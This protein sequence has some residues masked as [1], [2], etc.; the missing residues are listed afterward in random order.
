MSNKPADAKREVAASA[1]GAIE[2]RLVRALDTPHLAD[3]VP[4]LP[5][6]TLYQVVRLRGVEHCGD[7]LAAA[8]PAQLGSLLDLDLWRSAAAGLDEQF[9]RVR[10]VEWIEG[11]TQAGDEQAATIAS[12][13][14]VHLLVTGLSRCVRIFDPA[15]LAPLA[16]DDD[17]HDDPAARPAPGSMDIGG[18]VVQARV[19][20]GWDAIVALL[21][22]LAWD[23]HEYFNAVMRGCR[24]LSNSRPEVDGLDNLFG[25]SEQ[26]QYDVSQSRADRR[27]QRGFLSPADARAFLQGAR[28]SQDDAR[29]PGMHPTATAYIRATDDDPPDVQSSTR[30]E[31]SAQEVE[32]YA[33][34]VPPVAEEAH[35]VGAAVRET[36]ATV[37]ALIAEASTSPA[38]P[39]ALIAGATGVDARRARVHALLE[40]LRASGAAAFEQR[41]REA[42]FLSNALV[43]GCSLQAR[44]FTAQEASDAALACCNLALD[45]Q[46]PGRDV[47]DSFLSDHDLLSLFQ[48]GW[49]AL[50][51]TSLFVARRLAD[52]LR[53]VQSLDTKTH[54]GLVILRR[55]LE[56][57]CAAG[58]PWGVR[59]SLDVL[60]ILDTVAWTGLLGA[61]DECPHVPDALTAIVERRKGAVSATAFSFVATA[62]DLA[63]MRL[64]ADRMAE[65]FGAP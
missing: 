4:R 1:P 44:S 55:D 60:A 6:D 61:L 53:P 35:A 52:V 3:V 25:H 18:Y 41:S 36:V 42:A 31:A 39:R 15:T 59:D 57:C 30:G 8:T 28:T 47:A 19:R 37:A 65:A 27:S 12:R 24:R 63:T 54:Q 64:F 9:D 2:D 16:S 21:T 49:A 34:G 20:D 7:L 23:H 11:L 17:P 58:S 10:F 48:Q 5:A 26:L 33:P 62:D 40:A 14:D 56:R 32:A 22:T 13:I 51:G 50:H 46:A 29:L 38:R 43:A 45:L